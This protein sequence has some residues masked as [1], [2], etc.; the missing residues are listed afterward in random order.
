M[1]VLASSLLLHQDM[2]RDMFSMSPRK[3]GFES[4]GKG[5]AVNSLRYVQN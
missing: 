3:D 2:C 5:S 1:S 4:T